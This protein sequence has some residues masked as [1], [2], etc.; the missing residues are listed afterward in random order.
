MG[1]VSSVENQDDSKSNEREVLIPERL[2]QL[3]EALKHQKINM[4]MFIEHAMTI[5]EPYRFIITIQGN[6]HHINCGADYWRVSYTTSK[7]LESLLNCDTLQVVSS[8]VGRG[9]GGDFDRFENDDIESKL[10]TYPHG[11][12]PHEGLIKSHFPRLSSPRNVFV[13]DDYRS[14]YPYYVEDL[15][16]DS[17]ACDIYFILRKLPDPEITMDRVLCKWVFIKSD[18]WR[19]LPIDLMNFVA[20][21]LPEENEFDDCPFWGKT[22]RPSTKWVAVGIHH[23]EQIIDKWI[24]STARSYPLW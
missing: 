17:E 3:K 7:S 5:E 4:A 18:L 11:M 9:A 14:R 12:F 20:T 22:T 8:T 10:L 13:N 2:L 21:F 16:Y 15:I 1:C 23:D 24:F 19:T 6:L